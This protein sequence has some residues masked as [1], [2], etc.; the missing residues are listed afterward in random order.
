MQGTLVALAPNQQRAIAT[1]KSRTCIQE[2]LAI[3]DS[4][5]QGATDLAHI[6]YASLGQGV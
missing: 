4:W 5:Q 1:P 3:G 2:R 6:G